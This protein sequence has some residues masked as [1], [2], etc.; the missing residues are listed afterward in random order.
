MACQVSLCTDKLAKQFQD[1]CF[2]SNRELRAAKI[3]SVGSSATLAEYSWN[4]PLSSENCV[5]TTQVTS[6]IKRTCKVDQCTRGISRV[7]FFFQ[8]GNQAFTQEHFRVTASL[9]GD[10][11]LKRRARA[12]IMKTIASPKPLLV[13][14]HVAGAG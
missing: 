4:W 1:A 13:T 10:N 6:C 9:G 14:D 3:K 12:E 2:S 11:P 5:T 8:H 7:R